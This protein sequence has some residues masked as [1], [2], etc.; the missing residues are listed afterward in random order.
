MVG[1]GPSLPDS[2][3]M[4]DC[5]KILSDPSRRQCF[6]AKVLH[7]FE[8]PAPGKARSASHLLFGRSEL[9]CLLSNQSLLDQVQLLATE[10]G[11]Y[12]EIDTSCDD[13]DYREACA[14][15]LDR[16]R[17]LRKQHAK[18]CLV[19]G[20]EITIKV[21]E[22]SGIGG[23]NQHF[24][25]YTA[26]QLREEDSPM[27]MISMGS[28]GIDGNSSAAGAVIDSLTME[29]IEALHLDA[30]VALARFD[31]NA[32]FEALGDAMNTGPTGNN[33]RDVRVF[34]SG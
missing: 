26:T 25:L 13:W 3:T 30:S 2:S 23:R 24:A 29:R 5:K 31:S 12:T 10:A 1:S 14:Y 7:Y 21:T 28:D 8:G 19:T 6:D 11:F 32:I 20:G 18:V 15:L 34:V 17:T 9:T 27:A 33:V 22:P 4:E 16:M